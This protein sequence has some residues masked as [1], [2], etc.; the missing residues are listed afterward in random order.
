MDRILYVGAPDLQTRRDIFAIRQGKMAV[1]AGVD[2]DELARLVSG[3]LPLIVC[4]R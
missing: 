4:P 2:I 1:G 3:E